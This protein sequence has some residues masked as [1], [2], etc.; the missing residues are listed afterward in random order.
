MSA[1]LAVIIPFFNTASYIE[2]LR[3]S[4][5]HQGAIDLEVIAVDDGSTDG[6]REALE[7]WAAEDDRLH[8]LSQVNR[9]S[10]QLAIWHCVTSVI[11]W[12]GLLT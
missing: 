4:L 8:V 9:G 3:D 5:N 12:I 1:N 7:Q 6:T 10:Q 11:G 2:G